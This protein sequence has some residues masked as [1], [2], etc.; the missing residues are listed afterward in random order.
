MSS[1][2]GDYFLL[3]QVNLQDA[4]FVRSSYQEIKNDFRLTLEV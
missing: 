4:P 1:P 2:P 3:L